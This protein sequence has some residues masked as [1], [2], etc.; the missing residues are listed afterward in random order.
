MIC[1]LTSIEEISDKFLGLLLLRLFT[2][3]LL[4]SSPTFKLQL[5]TWSSNTLEYFGVFTF[6]ETPGEDTFVFGEFPGS[7][8]GTTILGSFSLDFLV[9]VISLSTSSYV[10]PS[11][12]PPSGESI[13]CETLHGMTTGGSTIF[14]FKFSPITASM[15]SI[16]G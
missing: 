4:F 11:L 2:F 16:V 1:L 12:L 13:S 9:S 7:K 15:G 8:S 10:S 3:S 5:P 6:G 14:R